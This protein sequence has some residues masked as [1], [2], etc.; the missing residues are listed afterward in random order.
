MHPGVQSLPGESHGIGRVDCRLEV[1][2]T[3]VTATSEPTSQ[4]QQAQSTFH[5]V[6]SGDTLGKMAKDLY[7]DA[8][9][10]PVIFEANRP[11]LSDPDKIYPGQSLRIPPL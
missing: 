4:A 3:P 10:Y 5:R 8:G 11:M 2:A 6:K 1:E 7:G 9:K